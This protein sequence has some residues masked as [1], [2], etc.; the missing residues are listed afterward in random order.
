MILIMVNDHLVNVLIITILCLLFMIICYC[1]LAST[2]HGQ[3]QWQALGAGVSSLTI[4]DES[5][6]AI[7][8]V[9]AT[10]LVMTLGRQLRGGFTRLEGGNWNRWNSPGRG[11]FSRDSAYWRSLLEEVVF[12]GS[13]CLYWKRFMALSIAG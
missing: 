1:C 13:G 5:G 6:N 4:T 12:T 8:V 10:D 9:S 11:G 7:T 3:L 2:A